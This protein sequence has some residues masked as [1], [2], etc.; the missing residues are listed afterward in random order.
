VTGQRN[1]TSY[2]SA[3]LHEAPG[4]RVLS[5]GSMTTGLAAEGY[6]VT[7]VPLV[8]PLRWP[9]GEADAVVCATGLGTGSSS[10]HMRILKSARDRLARGGVLI[11]SQRLLSAA[12]MSRPAGG[13]DPVR[14]M[15]ADGERLY[16]IPELRALLRRAGFAVQQVDADF[17]V[18][19]APTNRTIEAQLVARPLPTPPRALAGG[20]AGGEPLPDQALDLRWAPDEAAWLEPTPRSLW[21]ALLEEDHT[22]GADAARHYALD[23]PYGANRATAVVSAHFQV[24]VGEPS[25]TFGAGATALLC[26]LA[27]LADEGQVLIASATHPDLPAWCVSGGC[28]LR[29]VPVNPSA[30]RLAAEIE[31]SAPAMAHLDQPSI[32]GRVL[33]LA[34]AELIAVAAA[35][36]GTI[37]SVDETCATYLGPAAS[38]IALVNR[39][40]NLVVTRSLSKGYCWGGLRIG[41]TVASPGIAHR[42]RGLVPPLQTSE[43]AYQMGLRLLAAGDMF[44]RLRARVSANKQDLVGLL[45]GLGIEVFRGDPA[46]PWVLAA[47]PAGTVTQTLRA[48][49]VLGKTFHADL[50]GDPRTAML[51]LSVPLSVERLNACRSLL[52]P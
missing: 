37:L 43:L 21:Q 4:N 34:E 48:R 38:A 26:S 32:T 9:D 39:F 50:S 42:I 46:L 29:T 13:Y 6:R 22:L 19:A 12:V 40:E 52:R 44:A 20:S 28:E 33:S 47:D 51:R 1:K 17:T 16:T 7:A 31:A 23:D 41:F 10:A 27:G 45:R 14:G 5:V 35:R 11:V 2:L 24:R 36:A 15:L 8:R 30:A 3:V 18:G 49:G 25:L